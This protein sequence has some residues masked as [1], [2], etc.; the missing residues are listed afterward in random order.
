MLES[1]EHEDV[2]LRYTPMV[3][4]FDADPHCYLVALDGFAISLLQS[5][6][7][8]AHWAARWG[9]LG[10]TPFID[11]D[12]R[13][14]EIEEC[15]MSGC[16][17]AALVDAIETG[18]AQLHED[19]TMLAGQGTDLVQ[20]GDNVGELEDD[21]ANVWFTVKAVATILGATVGAPPTPL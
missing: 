12:H 21:L 4:A 15:L 3:A 2:Y 19:L 11:V 9:D 5:V 7:R 14:N 8:Y 20:I 18:F 1:S 16:D 13:V 10:Q 17:V 6:L